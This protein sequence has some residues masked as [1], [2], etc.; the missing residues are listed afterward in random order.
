MDLN[1][2]SLKAA[3]DELEKLLA[4]KVVVGEQ[5]TI[6]DHVVIPLCSCGFG[7]GAG[8]GGGDESTRKGKSA[9][10]AHQH[11]GWGS[12]LGFGG[13]VRPVGVI[14]GGPDGVRVEPLASDAGLTI[15]KIRSIV[16]DIGAQASA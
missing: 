15:D 10:D 5:I 2:A 7:L 12:G 9:S 4:T 8:R 6:N 3:L 16:Q 13:G 14:I 1:D 11:Q